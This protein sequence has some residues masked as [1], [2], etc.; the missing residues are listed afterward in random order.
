MLCDF[1]R[2][3]SRMVPEV[4]KPKDSPPLSSSFA[5]ILRGQSRTLYYFLSRYIA[6]LGEQASKSGYV[7]NYVCSAS[8]LSLPLQTFKFLVILAD[9]A[10]SQFHRWLKFFSFGVCTNS[11]CSFYENIETFLID[12]LITKRGGRNNWHTRRYSSGKRTLYSLIK[13]RWYYPRLYACGR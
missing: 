8:I 12:N 1:R 7:G 5:I 13:T 9:T 2:P 10:I 3:L 4:D 11:V 6:L